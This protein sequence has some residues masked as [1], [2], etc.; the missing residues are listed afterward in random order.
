MK[1]KISKWP[2]ILLLSL[3]A[4]YFLFIKSYVVCIVTIALLIGLYKQIEFARKLAILGLI[5]IS[6]GL[7]FI[8]FPMNIEYE[9]TFF[10]SLSTAYKI[11][12][13]VLAET[14]ILF[15]LSTMR[16]RF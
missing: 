4:I 12:L 15:T 8:F 3:F 11:P 6:I 14:L 7:I 1:I 9:G 16:G 13:L 10:Y 5:L 2:S